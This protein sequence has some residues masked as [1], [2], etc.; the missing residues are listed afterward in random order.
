[1]WEETVSLGTFGEEVIGLRDRL[2]VTGSLR[3]DGS[4]SFGDA[5]H[6]RPYPKIGLSWIASEEPWLRDVPGLTELRFRGSYGVSS[7]YPT[8]FMKLGSLESD[9]MNFDGTTRSVFFRGELANPLLRPER[10]RE[11][12][13]GTDATVLRGVTVGLSWYR[14]RTNDLL[15]GIANPFGLQS[16][17][18]NT[19]SLDA[20]GFEA[21]MNVPIVATSAIRSDISLQYSANRS[22][23]VNVGA[24]P[25][26]YAVGYPVDA[27]FGSR[28]LTV[29]DT[30]G[31]G[32]GNAPDGIVFPNEVVRDSVRRFLG[33]TNPPRTY[34][35]IPTVALLNGRLRISS[36]FDRSMGYL[37]LDAFSE[38][39]L[40]LCLA[41]I[42]KSTPL[43]EQAK[44]AS[45]PH[46][47]DFYVP[48]DNTRWRE[49]NISFD[50]PERFL[51]LDFIHL[52]F[53]RATA[54]MQGRNLKL[55]TAYRGPDPDSRNLG[56]DNA[57]AAGIP[58]TR[59]W[60]FRFD[61]TP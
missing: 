20:H 17:W 40:Q 39:C 53:S 26:G 57:T 49:L 6:P 32:A 16:V 58:Q 46:D 38:R 59:G 10:T 30:V 60:S 11:T 27:V 22:R 31:T 61:L 35:V 5:Y 7:R 9:L 24:A 52:R 43:L 28:I 37:V 33:V 51:Q 12:E 48:G 4:T 44:Y 34:T 14:R 55:W 25:S 8:S 45:Y 42:L 13:Y 29:L 54:S 3:V 15:Q 23:V 19:A 21:T 56:F 41:T 1:V 36:L 18:A 47:D 50:L 2:F